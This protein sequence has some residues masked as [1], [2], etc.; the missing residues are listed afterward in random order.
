MYYFL[1]GTTNP[2]RYSLLM[3]NYNTRSQFRNVIR[4]LDRRS[5]RYVVWD[6]KF[7]TKASQ[8]FSAAMNRPAGGL[9][10]EPYLE[11]HYRIVKDVDGVRI[12]ERKEQ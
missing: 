9:V 10:I 8:Y 11:S 5:V 7:E 2:T 1:S 4:I 3:Y 6:T 12:M